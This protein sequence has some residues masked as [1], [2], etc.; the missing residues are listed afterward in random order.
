MI[1]RVDQQYQLPL[2]LLRGAGC[3]INDMWDREFDAK[4]ERTKYRPIASGKI[5]VAEATGFLGLQL[6]LGL[7]ILLQLNDYSQVLGISSLPLVVVY[8]LMKR[9]TSL[10]CLPNISS[11][12]LLS[13]ICE[14]ESRRATGRMHAASSLPGTDDQLGCNHGMGIH[15]WVD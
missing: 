15:P 6:S 10:V 14:C 1:Q 8:P 13:A 2:Q 7:C 12:D 3:T 11:C 5:S 9:I 4:V